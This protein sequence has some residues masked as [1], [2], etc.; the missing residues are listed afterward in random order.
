[1]IMTRD[2][3]I[4][5]MAKAIAPI[6]VKEAL[7]LQQGIIQNGGDIENCTIGGKT[8]ISAYGD[9]IKIWATK[10]VEELDK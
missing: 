2:E 8:I 1:M 9:N 5:E 7:D 10:I 3:K 6:F 4:F